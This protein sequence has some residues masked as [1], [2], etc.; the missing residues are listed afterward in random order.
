MINEISHKYGLSLRAEGP[1]CIFNIATDNKE[2]LALF[3]NLLLEHGLFPGASCWFIQY[4]HTDDV[5]DL[6]GKII[7]TVCRKMK[8]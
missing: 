2:Q 3:T 7:D 4:S 8:K 1:A 6:A 5:I